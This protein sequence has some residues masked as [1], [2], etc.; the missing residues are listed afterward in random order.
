MKKLLTTIFLCGGLAT[1]FSCSNDES[2]YP[3]PS[4]IT[5]V[6][7]IPAPGSIMLSWDV[8]D[9]GNLKYVEVTYKI[10]ETNKTYRKQISKFA[11]TLQIDNLLQKYGSIDFTLQTFNPE[12]TGGKVYKVSAQAEK[13]LPTFGEP[14]KLKLNAASMYTNAPFT[15]RPL[16]ALIDGDLATFFHSQWQTEVL[17]PHYIVIDLGEKVEAFSFKSTNAN[18]DGDNSWQTVEIYGSDS[19]DPQAY[20]DGIKFIN[21]NTIDLSGSG[22]TLI[23]T[24]TALPGTKAA[25]YTSSIRSLEKPTRWLWFKATKTTDGVRPYFALAELEIYK[26]QIEDLE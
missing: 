19:Y 10:A 16:S 13:A 26:Y 4:D 14:Q 22:A 18:R 23:T 12:N 3:L 21:G 2:G 17:L 20:F 9:D 1:L 25:S 24:L 7:A 15:N 8:P 6:Q 5:N 11:D